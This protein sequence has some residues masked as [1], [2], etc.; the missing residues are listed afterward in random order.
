MEPSFSR[1]RSEK[2]LR[3][4]LPLEVDLV[5]P[6]GPVALGRGLVDVSRSG[7]RVRQYCFPPRIKLV[8]GLE[9]TAELRLRQERFSTRIQV[10]WF[11]QKHLGI[12]LT[13][14]VPF[15]PVKF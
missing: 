5:T 13:E 3:I 4:S 9:Y 15:W 7:C 2:R 11:D 14:A 8:P 10:V 12:R 6:I 1:K